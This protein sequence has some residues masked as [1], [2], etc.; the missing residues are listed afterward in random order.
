MASARPLS[1]LCPAGRGAESSCPG[2]AASRRVP[3]WPPDGAETP[4]FWTLFYPA[5]MLCEQCIAR[6]EDYLG[7]LIPTNQAVDA[8]NDCIDNVV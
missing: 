1:A 2:E 3:D 7:I 6:F 4:C 8:Y 5:L